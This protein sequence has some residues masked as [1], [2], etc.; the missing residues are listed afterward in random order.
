MIW[1]SLFLGVTFQFILVFGAYDLKNLNI[2]PM[3]E[4]VE[5]GNTSLFL[6]KD[7]HL[8]T[9]GSKYA[10]ASGI[11]KDGF[12]R[13]LDVITSNNVIEFNSKVDDSLLLQGMNVVIHSESDEVYFAFS[14]GSFF[15]DT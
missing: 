15:L 1:Q 6:S 9:N 11:L 12:T 14:F 5:Y 13:L 7:F 2:W 3:P 10:D 8:K 4:S